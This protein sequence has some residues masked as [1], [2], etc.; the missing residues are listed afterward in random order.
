VAGNGPSN[1]SI[2]RRA[3][4]PIGDKARIA[5]RFAFDFTKLGLPADGK[6]V[7]EDPK[8]NENWYAYGSEVLAVSD[9]A[10][11]AVKDDV[12]ENVPL[13]KN[14]AVPI[15]RET[16]GGNYVILDLGGGCFAYY[17]HM[18]PKSIRVKVGDRVRRGQILGLVGNSGNSDS[19]HLHFHIAE[20]NSPLDAEG[21]PFVFDS[22]EVLGTVDKLVTLTRNTGWNPQSGTVPEK[23]EKEMP[24]EN[25]II[26]F[27]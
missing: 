18:Q 22:Y 24:L 14:R 23:H 17:A 15:T 8:K 1:T 26:R 27:P 21:L 16:I 10:V 13:A 25:T 9:A 12:P 11:S 6:I 5:Q 19:P 7:H 4:Y 3:L 20:T 2:H